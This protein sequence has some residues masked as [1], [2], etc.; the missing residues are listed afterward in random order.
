MECK[1]EEESHHIEFMN[2]HLMTEEEPRF[3]E[4]TFGEIQCNC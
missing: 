2:D 3:R 4:P 1:I